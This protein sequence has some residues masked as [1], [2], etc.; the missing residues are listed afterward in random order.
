MVSPIVFQQLNT[1]RLTIPEHREPMLHLATCVTSAVQTMQTAV[2]S[3][4]SNQKSS[5]D[6]L[7]GTLRRSKD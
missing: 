3:V 2:V 5:A 7:P 4:G 1:K 6:M